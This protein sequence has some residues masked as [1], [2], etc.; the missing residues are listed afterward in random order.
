MRNPFRPTAGK[1]PPL[2]VGRDSQLGLIHEGL[3]NGPGDPNLLAFVTGLRGVGKTVMLAEISDIVRQQGWLVVD[4]TVTEG[5]LGRVSDQVSRLTRNHPAAGDK[6]RARV[7][8]LDAPLGLGGIGWDRS[9]PQDDRGLRQRLEDLLDTVEAHGA[10]VAFSIDEVRNTDEFRAL[11]VTIQQLLSSDRNVAVFMGGLP[12]AVSDI[13]AGHDGHNVLTFLRRAERIEL[14]DVD[15]DE[16]REALVETVTE[17]GKTISVEAALVAARATQGYPFMIQLVG[18]HSWRASGDS[19]ELTLEHVEAGAEVSQRKLGSL[20][21]A[22][23]L[24]D[25]SDVDRS[26]LL[27]MARDEGP[28]RIDDIRARLNVAP[29]YA[30]SYRQRLL[31]AGMI[32]QPSRGVVNLA[33]PYL[34]EYLVD[35]GASLVY[36]G[37][38]PVPAQSSTTGMGV[39]QPSCGRPVAATG[40][41]CRLRSGHGGRCRSR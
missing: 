31:D 5:L 19:A 10:G 8:R 36:G 15:E 1:R 14:D 38:L 27:A 9:L 22:T 33:L 26:F 4:D 40:L 2:L 3:A 11:T 28:S 37:A 18:Y 41:P 24:A 32:V 34:R 16:V 17:A 23:A 29:Q 21:H 20:V 12:T 35:H 30:N 25:L 39:P 6:S 7:N 13:V